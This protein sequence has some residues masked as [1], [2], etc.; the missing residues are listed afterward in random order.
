MNKKNFKSLLNSVNEAGEILRGELAPIREF[1]VEVAQ[2]P[3]HKKE[4]FALCIKSDEDKLL[5]PS[6]IYRAKFSSNN[7]IGVM[8]ETGESA[9][10]PADFFLKLDFPLEV[11]NVLESLQKV[12]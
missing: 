9:I 10:Y 12:A 11:E 1:Q 2:L 8:D 5:I 4:G 7:Y 3:I 6:K